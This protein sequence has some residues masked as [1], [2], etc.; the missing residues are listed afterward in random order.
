MKSFKKVV[1]T[2]ILA[3]TLVMGLSMVSSAAKSSPERQSIAKTDI[4]VKKAKYNGKKQMPEVV[5]RNSDGKKLKEGVDYVIEC[6]GRKDSGK[7]LFVI[8]GIGRYKGSVE[9]FFE[10]EPTASKKANKVTF[11]TNK[12][13]SF[14]SS[15]L[16][17]K[18]KKIKITVEK[19]KKNKGKVTYTLLT[20]SKHAKKY[21][22]ISDNG[23]V[24]LKKGLKKGTYVV[25]AKVLGNGKFAPRVQ[26]IKIVVK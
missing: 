1:V 2:M 14:K 7:K 12:K 5:I 9:K 18:N 16:K 3:M 26:K 15:D 20:K 4:T 22:S 6:E 24:T 11:K 13:P 21:I 25:K 17:K 10:I 8:K 23:V 19:N